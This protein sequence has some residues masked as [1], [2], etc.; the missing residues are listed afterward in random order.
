M[1]LTPHRSRSRRAVAVAALTATIA[2]GVPTAQVVPGEPDPS[3]A[4]TF[5]VLM[6]G[7]RIGTESV[8]ITRTDA[9]WVVSGAGRLQA[10]V[11]LTTN[12]FEVTYGADWQP[13]RLSIEASLRGQPL[14]LTTTFG[15]TTAASEMRQGAER[16]ASTRQVSPRSVVLPNNFFG[17]YET[18][19]IRLSS[20]AIGTRIPIFI[21]PNGETTI[22]VTQVTEKRVLIGDRPLALREF[23][24]TIANPA[25]AMPVE[26]WVDPR[27]RLARLVMPT[28]GIV[29]IREDL[30]TVMA[31][32]ERA[33]HP[34]DQDQFIGAD[35]F[36]LSA[37]LTRPARP[38]PRMP[39]VV[40]ASP[41]GP[42]DRDFISYGV[43]VF[44]QLAGAL[45]DAGYLAVRYDARGSG[46][47]GGRSE[48]ARLQEYSDDVINIVKWLR[49]RPDVDER[50]VSVVGYGDSGPIAL[51]SASREKAIAG[52]ALLA[53]PGRIG[54]EVTTEQQQLSLARMQVS[55][56][57][58]AGRLSLQTRVM[59]AVLTGKGWE[60]IP[61]DVRTQADTMWFRSWLLFDPSVTV[62]R[63]A[64][65]ILIL[66]G[67]LDAERPATHAAR[68]DTMARARE[69]SPSTHTRVRV[70][71]ALNH[72]LV[73][74]KTGEV[75][76]YSSLDSRV[77]S[78]EI[79]Q[80]LIEW[81]Q[82]LP[83]AR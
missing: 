44:A 74:A 29:A 40:L 68:L 67:A 27:G 36:S 50:R 76:E 52:V 33:R 11:D 23:A 81:L 8:S 38:A 17:A 57:E 4:A 61:D 45:A 53:S 2:V 48:A 79:S 71:P 59:D 31:R 34:G 20:S 55:D 37:T 49:K 6:T 69:K 16:G 43:P 83:A 15:L 39:A 80:A 1:G 18:L 25:G 46:R 73:A 54:R 35:G 7:T 56:A 75:D 60:N 70:V 77:V 62:R 3:G 24:L 21:A 78:A 42:Q 47:S 9:G 72:L 22:T 64:Q 26:L 58:K 13:Q 32:E 10:P 30:A 65:P 66:H 41:P 14:T 28:S 63:V 5:V 12:K 82:A 51:L 19:A